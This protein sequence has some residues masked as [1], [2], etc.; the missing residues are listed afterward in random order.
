MKTYL[1]FPQK[2]TD[3]TSFEFMGLNQKTTNNNIARLSL[4][5]ISPDISYFYQLTMALNA[6][7]FEGF[8]KTLLEFK[9]Y[10]V[11]NNLSL[12]KYIELN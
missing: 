10:M 4:I 6:I 1:K 5:V 12:N 9:M 2:I 7:V 3:I 11:C 8:P